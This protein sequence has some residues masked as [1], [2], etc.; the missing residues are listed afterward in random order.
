[1]TRQAI[2]LLIAS[3][4]VGCGAVL[5]ITDFGPPVE[6]NADGAMP[7]VVGVESEGGDAGPRDGGPMADPDASDGDAD[8]NLS[9]LTLGDAFDP[10]CVGDL[11]Y[12]NAKLA[13]L[14]GFSYAA[15]TCGV[16]HAGCDVSVC[17]NRKKGRTFCSNKRGIVVTDMARCSTPP[18]SEQDCW[19]LPTS[20]RTLEP[21]LVQM[22]D[23]I[24]GFKFCNSA[25][26]PLP[27]NFVGARSLCQA[28]REGDDYA[29]C[30]SSS[31]VP[32]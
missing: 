22:C 19:V 32:P 21:P 18:A 17:T 7:P 14:D 23:Q 11:T 1:M 16:C 26:D 8:A 29:L 3:T 15:M 25:G 13:T 6:V 10:V 4:L 31:P 12:W 2:A 5:G 9:C 28:I 20:C 24:S 27:G 30:P